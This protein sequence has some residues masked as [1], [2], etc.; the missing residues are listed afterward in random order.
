MKL[1]IVCSAHGFGHL[2]RQLAVGEVLRQ[3]GVEPTFFTAAPRPIVETSLPGAWVVP[4]VADVGIAQPDSVTEDLDETLRRLD[5]VCLE[6]AVDRLA[7]ALGGFDRVVVDTAPAA[8]EAARRAGVEALA[9]GNFEW[10][11]LYEHYPRLRDWARRFR[12]WQGPHVGLE[13]WPGPGL[14]HF[15]KIERYGLVARK[16]EP[17]RLPPGAVLVSFGGFGLADLDRRLPRLEGVTWVLSPPMVRLERPDVL[18]VDDVAYPALVG[19]ASLLLTK[20]GYGILAEALCAGTPIAWIDRGAFPEAASLVAVL[21][22]RGDRRVARLEEIARLDLP[23]R[24]PVALAT[25]RL[26]RRYLE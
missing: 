22:E 19:G 8:L 5:R 10:A 18:W 2:T 16:R 13:L 4:W 17:H 6:E 3:H 9:V 24:E 26:G 20:P 14:H 15:Q 25:G 21:E 11:W 12:G 7:E 23:R 1:A